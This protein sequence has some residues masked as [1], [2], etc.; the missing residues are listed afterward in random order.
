[1]IFTD[2]RQDQLEK[3]IKASN[4]FPESP[5]ELLSKYGTYNIQPTAD[6]DN[7]FPAIAQGKQN[8]KRQKKPGD[9]NG[10]GTKQ[11]N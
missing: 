3:S 5:D 10:S 11:P 4:G 9:Q 6:T 1:M 7:P 8:V 2:K